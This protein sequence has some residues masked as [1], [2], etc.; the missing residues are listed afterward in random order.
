[1]IARILERRLVCR[2]V[3]EQLISPATTLDL[4][5]VLSKTGGKRSGALAA[6][7]LAR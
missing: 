2:G 6:I 3:L 4:E 5:P 7:L 1:M